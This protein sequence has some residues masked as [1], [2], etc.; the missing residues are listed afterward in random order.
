MSELIQY[1]ICLPLSIFFSDTCKP[2]PTPDAVHT[3]AVNS[4]P[5][6]VRRKLCLFPKHFMLCFSFR[7]V[8]GNVWESFQSVE[9]R[10]WWNYR[11]KGNLQTSQSVNGYWS[12]YHR[13]MYVTLFFCEMLTTCDQNI[14]RILSHFSCSVDFQTGILL[15]FFTGLR[16]QFEKKMEKMKME[17]TSHCFFSCW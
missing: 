12:K 2:Y 15:L 8:L 3:K 4:T 16:R 1:L 11:T 17:W 6:G 9:G 5:E 14:S 13:A 10:S 7:F